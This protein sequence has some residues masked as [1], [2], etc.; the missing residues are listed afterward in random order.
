MELA[1]S[2]V[3]ILNGFGVCRFARSQPQ[4]DDEA[5]RGANWCMDSLVHF[6]VPFVYPTDRVE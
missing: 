3:S 5:T 1:R 6:R 4:K 2:A